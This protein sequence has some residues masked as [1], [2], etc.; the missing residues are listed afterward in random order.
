MLV[1]PLTTSRALDGPDASPAGDRALTRPRVLS[2]AVAVDP[3]AWTFDRTPRVAPVLG[4][5]GTNDLLVASPYTG[6]AVQS[7]DDGATWSEAPGFPAVTKGRVAFDPTDP[8]VGYVAG[9]GGVARTLDAGLTWDLALA[10]F[11]AARIDVGPDGRVLV[12]AREVD[13]SNHVL[14]SLDRGETWHD[15][16]APLPAFDPICGVAYGRT[17]AEML[18]MTNRRS[19]YSH[20]GGATWIETPG[21]GFEFGIED[22]GA[23]WR[24]DFGL[25]QRTLDGGESW[26]HVDAPGSGTAIA[27]HP[28]GGVV[29]STNAGILRVRPDLSFAELGGGSIAAGV[30]SVAVVAPDAVVVGHERIGIARIDT[31]GV[32]SL[33]VAPFPP[34]ALHAVEVDEIGGMLT[35]A[36]PAGAWSSRDGGA[37]WQHMGAGLVTFAKRLAIGAGGASIVIGGSSFGGQSQVE[38]ST[39]GGRSFLR[40][41][42]SGE[43]TVADVAAHPNDPQVAFAAVASASPLHA[44]HRTLDGGVTWEAILETPL[45]IHDIAWDAQQNALVAA[46]S[47]GVLSFDGALWTP[48]GAPGNATA[49]DVTP[50]GRMFAATSEILWHRDPS[51]IA[52]TPWGLASAARAL[53]AALAPD[54]IW[55]ALSDGELARCT[56]S[57]LLAMC[58]A[59]GPGVGAL[60]IATRGTRVFAATSEGLAATG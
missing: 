28:E 32:R 4:V 29:V 46:T 18:T 37:T 1:A 3:D 33:H 35:A 19:W 13:G 52:L 53:R 55:L 40:A 31:E 44:L 20:D 23:V 9:Y 5:G 56:K 51:E 7:R 22:T 41:T 12:G 39:D 16:G 36:G 48:L 43:G 59:A 54:V 17:S 30:G 2:T 24:A 26:A 6:S 25:L 14:E 50:E 34:A 45:A 27:P 57:D 8:L 60:D 38:I 42:L 10:I 47:V 11:R 49:L 58:E 15:R 21:A